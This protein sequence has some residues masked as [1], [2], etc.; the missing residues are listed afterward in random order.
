MAREIK[1]GKFVAHV[2]DYSIKSTKNGDPEP[3]VRFKWLDADGDQKQLNWRGTLKEG[4][5]REITLA[6]LVLCGFQGDDLSVLCD[7]VESGALNTENPVSISVEIEKGT[8][9]KD[10]PKIAWINDPNAG[11]FKAEMSKDEA[12]QK[13]GALKLGGDLAAAKSKATPRA[14]AAAVTPIDPSAIPF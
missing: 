12:R 5:G 8:D 6:S 10:Y 13:L 1:P 9:G 11:G 4:K 3:V 7:G 14:S 2:V